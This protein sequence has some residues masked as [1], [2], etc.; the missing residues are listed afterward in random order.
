MSC[1][2]RHLKDILDQAGIAV[3]P[4]NK[5]QID[6]FFHKLAGVDYKDCPAAWKRLKQDTLANEE[7]RRDLVQK[8]KSA[9]G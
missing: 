5:R 8:L 1:Y 4:D 2:F 9:I 6:Q 3:T 7:K